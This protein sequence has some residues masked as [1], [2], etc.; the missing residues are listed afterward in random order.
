MAEVQGTA[1]YKWSLLSQVLYVFGVAF[2][3]RLDYGNQCV[4]ML[5]LYIYSLHF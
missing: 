1:K 4:E 2:L 3:H 5:L